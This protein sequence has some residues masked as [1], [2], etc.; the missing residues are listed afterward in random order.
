[1]APVIV[2]SGVPASGKTTVSRLLAARFARAAHIEADTLQKMIVSGGEWP[3]LPPGGEG[4]RQLRLRAANACLLA[5]SFAT[6][7]FTAIVD[8]IVLGNRIGEFLGALAGLDVH[9]VQLC[10]SLE[11]VRQRDVL[12]DKHA[13]FQS[14]Y[15][16]PILRNET[17]RAGLWLDTTDMIAEDA[18]TMILAR[19]PESLVMSAGPL[20][21]SR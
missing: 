5:R 9:L 10:P 12:R 18:V 17:E 3:S 14:E 15:L 2:V 6:A 19:L 8:D 11:A 13:F 21:G 1:M 16:E 7:G 4:L 20:A